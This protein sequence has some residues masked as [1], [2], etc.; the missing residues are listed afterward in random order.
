MTRWMCI[1]LLGLLS[2]TLVKQ[3]SGQAQRGGISGVVTDQGGAVLKGAQVTLESPVFNLVTDDEGRFVINNVAPGNYT[4]TITYVGFA[5]FEQ[6]LSVSAGQVANVP[7]KLQL[8]SQNESILVTIPRVSGEADAV[9]I[10]RS[11]DN[12]VQVLPAEV[13]RSLPNANLADALGR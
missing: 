11:A 7:V 6:S 2:L 10:E 13:I 4:L 12:L 8:Q 9:N 3:A 1:L 5:K